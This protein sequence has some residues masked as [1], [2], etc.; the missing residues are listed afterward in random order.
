MVKLHVKAA[1]FTNADIILILFWSDLF[2]G[3]GKAGGDECIDVIV[4]HFGIRSF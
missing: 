1:T 2:R 3:F 4:N